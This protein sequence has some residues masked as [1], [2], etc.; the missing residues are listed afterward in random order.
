MQKTFQKMG[1]TFQE[2]AVLEQRNQLIHEQNSQLLR[3]LYR[4]DHKGGQRETPEEQAAQEGAVNAQSPPASSNVQVG[5]VDLSQT[6]QWDHGFIDPVIAAD[7]HTYERETIE[8]YMKVRLETGLELRSP[9]SNQVLA[10]TMLTP[11][12]RAQ[13]GNRQSASSGQPSSGGFKEVRISP[14]GVKSANV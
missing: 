9:T 14:G 1:P 2:L 4:R 6:S 8:A 7:G 5:A 13:H 12:T 11:V 10:H 3:A